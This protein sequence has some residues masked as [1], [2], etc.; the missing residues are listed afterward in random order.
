MGFSQGRDT[1][2]KI[3]TISVTTNGVTE[4]S[5]QD[6]HSEPVDLYLYRRDQAPTLTTAIVVDDVRFEVDSTTGISAGDALT[7]YEDTQFYQTLVNATSGSAVT[8]YTPCDK[9][10]T[11]SAIVQVGPWNMAVDGSTVS[12]VFHVHPPVGVDFDIYH[13]TMTGL[14]E[15]EMDSTTFI[16]ISGG[17]SM[18]TLF[19]LNNGIMKN[20]GLFVNNLGLTEFGYDVTYVAA[21]KKS[22]YGLIAVQDYHQKAGISIRLLGASSDA[23][24]VVIRD[25]LTSQTLMAVIMKGHVVTDD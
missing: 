13:I 15:I 2:K 19:R 18:G 12:Q 5:V 1:N 20:M 4:V 6:Q 9:V 25:D 17:I 24:E 3:H 14:D 11:T 7:I 10:F 22:Q 8:V 16:G 23:F 21:N